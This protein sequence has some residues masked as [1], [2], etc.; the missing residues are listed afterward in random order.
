MKNMDCPSFF[1]EVKRERLFFLESL[2]CIGLLILVYRDISGNIRDRGK[3]DEC[4]TQE[5]LDFLEEQGI[6]HGIQ[7]K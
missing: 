3:R 4:S 5:I 2:L 1:T 6:M 7:R